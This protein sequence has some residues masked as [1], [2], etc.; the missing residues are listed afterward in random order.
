MRNKVVRLLTMT[1]AITNANSAQQAWG[2]EQTPSAVTPENAQARV[3]EIGEQ[4]KV[5]VVASAHHSSTWQKAVASSSFPLPIYTQGEAEMEN[6][7]FNLEAAG[8]YKFLA[9]RTKDSPAAVIA[10]YKTA[11][12]GKG[13]NLVAG[14]SPQGRG[15]ETLKAESSSKSAYVVVGASNEAGVTSIQLILTDKVRGI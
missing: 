3:K 9:L 1:L 6:T 13:L 7:R 10:W 4:I 5:Q 2:Q 14:T 11:L 12:P 15:I 8:K